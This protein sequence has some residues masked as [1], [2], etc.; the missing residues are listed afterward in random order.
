MKN[1]LKDTESFNRKKE[2]SKVSSSKATNKRLNVKDRIE[3]VANWNCDLPLSSNN[4]E[5]G[6]SRLS[7]KNSPIFKIKVDSP[8]PNSPLPESPLRNSPLPM[9]RMI[10][11]KTGVEKFGEKYGENFTI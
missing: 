5:R 4:S 8:L 1:I 9:N 10:S 11:E 3:K 7:G 6:S 2:S